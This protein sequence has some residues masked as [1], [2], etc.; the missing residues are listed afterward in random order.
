MEKNM[1]VILG[2]SD[3]EMSLIESLCREHSIPYAY[4]TDPDGRRVH[5]GNAYQVAGLQ[6]PGKAGG[7][8]WGDVTHLVECSPSSEHQDAI[9]PDVVVIDHHRPGDP[10]YGRGP[11][12]FLGASSLGQFIAEL[13]RR[14]VRLTRPYP[15]CYDHGWIPGRVD[16][17]AG[18]PIDE[19]GEVIEP[20]PL[21]WFA[22]CSNG[23][24]AVAV[25]DGYSSVRLPAIVAL[26]AAAD[27]CL[28]SAYRGRCPGVDPDALMRWRAESRAAFQRRP[29]EAVLADIEAARQRLR[30]ACA[31]STSLP[32][33]DLRGESIPELPEA[34][35]REGIPFLADQT[36]RSGRRKVVLMAA[37][38]DL[39][40]RFLSGEIVPGLVDYYGDPARGFAGGY[41]WAEENSGN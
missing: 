23:D 29:V 1:L 6:W 36:D 4:A 20:D 34:A 19:D 38:P 18:P 10:G 37:P 13:A 15:E 25:E 40:R 35:A 30:A 17:W 7:P 9:P 33:A 31:A 21:G 5:P 24:W 8:G 27:H 32:Y 12:E 2:A 3:P 14:G 22:L 39:V 26:T 11:E 41:Y 28:E 16:T